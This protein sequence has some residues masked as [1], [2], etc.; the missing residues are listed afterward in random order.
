MRGQIK[1]DDVQVN[2]WINVYVRVKH[3]SALITE[4]QLKL[5]QSR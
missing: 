2:V 4:R 5:G 3:G 1:K